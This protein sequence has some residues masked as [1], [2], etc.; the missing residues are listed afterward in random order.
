MKR[1]LLFL[2]CLML[3]LPALAASTDQIATQAKAA[4]AISVPA[5][6]TLAAQPTAIA[7]NPKWFNGNWI[8]LEGFGD[9]NNAEGWAAAKGVAEQK[10]AY[11]AAHEAKDVNGI[12][13]NAFWT[14]VQGWALNNAGHRLL[15]SITEGVSSPDTKAKAAQAEK[16]LQ[17]AIDLVNNAADLPKVSGALG[18]AYENEY[19]QRQAVLEKAAKNLAYANHLTGKVQWPKVAKAEEQD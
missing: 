11:Q 13:E 12:V 15:E 16:Y 6:V 7:E 19:H 14:S 9:P 17:K 8:G 1:T 5:S 10:K 3:A 2:A 18:I 4:A